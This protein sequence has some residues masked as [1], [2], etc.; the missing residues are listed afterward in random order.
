MKASM[1]S[2]L[3]A[4]CIATLPA[5]ATTP[6]PTAEPSGEAATKSSS[7]PAFVPPARPLVLL[8][9]EEVELKTRDKLTLKASWYEPRKK[10][11]QT[12]GVVLVHD[13]GADRASLDV[14]ATRLQK[15]GFAVLSVDL[16]GHGGSKTEALDWDKLND[17]DRKAQWAFAQR[18]VDAAVDWLLDQDNVHSTRLSLVGHGAGCALAVR[19]MRDDDNAVAIALIEPS[20]K[21]FGFEVDKDLVDLEGL[22]TYVVA[23]RDGDEEGTKAMVEEANSISGGDPFVELWLTRPPILEDRK[24]AA[25]VS[26]F[27]EQ[28]A[29]PKKG[30]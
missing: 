4:L 19:H 13:A 23:P 26:G 30:K 5:V 1:L 17:E 27:L 28:H 22:P 12:P 24:T 18:D 21:V 14:L 15:E 11:R 7:A 9:A 29:M 2:G 8:D 6:A 16:R 20:P 10:K 3:T 25:K